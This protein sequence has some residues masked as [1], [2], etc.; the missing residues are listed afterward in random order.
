VTAGGDFMINVQRVAGG[1]AV[2]LIRY[3]FDP[4]QDRT[5]L[6]PDLTIELRLPERFGSVSTHSPGGQMTGELESDG[7]MHRIR[8]RDVALYGVALL[9]PA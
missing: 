8:L 1:A 7:H 2:H 4:E 6:L 9:E 3:D 5:P